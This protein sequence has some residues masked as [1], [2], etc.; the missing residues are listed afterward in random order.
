MSGQNDVSITKGGQSSLLARATSALGTVY[1]GL[2]HG[3]GK[4]LKSTRNRTSLQ[5]G[6]ACLRCPS[7][8]II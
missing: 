6:L 5:K 8:C 3:L 2:A 4:T 7:S 1:Y